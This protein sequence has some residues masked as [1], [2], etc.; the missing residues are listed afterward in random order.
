MALAADVHRPYK[1]KSILRMCVGV[2]TC[3]A[4]LT[5]EEK[6]IAVKYV[7]WFPI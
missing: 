3:F 2:Y 7:S 5:G 1:K 6:K 4:L